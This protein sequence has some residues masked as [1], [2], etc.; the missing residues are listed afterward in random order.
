MEEVEADTRSG[1]RRCCCSVPAAREHETERLTERLGGVAVHVHELGMVA[2]VRRQRHMPCA[3]QAHAA[4]CRRP[5]QAKMTIRP[6]HSS[7]AHASRCRRFRWVCPW[8]PVFI[9]RWRYDDPSPDESAE[10]AR[11]VEGKIEAVEDKREEVEGAAE[12]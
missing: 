9:R 11:D 8:C 4:A 10:Y 1:E 3:G 7:S 6:H 2:C 12:A 5:R